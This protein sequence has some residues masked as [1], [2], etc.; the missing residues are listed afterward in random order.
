MPKLSQKLKNGSAQVGPSSRTAPLWKGPAEDGVTFSLLSRY[1]ACKERF[2]LQ[3]IEGMATQD[4]FNPRLEFGN[5]WHICEEALA[6]E[7]RHFGEVV[8]TTLW[9]DD[10]RKY[11]QGLVKRFSKQGQN[12][13][14]KI[15]HWFNI[16]SSLFPRYVAYWN[17]HPDVVNR[18]PIMQEEKFKIMYQ[19]PSK[20]IVY[21][22]GK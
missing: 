3:V 16:C 20:R 12:Y 9:D 11:C 8:G 19:L 21:L 13:Q 17:K 5:M 15:Y 10:L 7:A 18:R 22:R 14:E 4:E 2:R 1:L 6:S